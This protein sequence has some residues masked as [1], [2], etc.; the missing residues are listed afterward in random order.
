MTED[1]QSQKY[2]I[3]CGATLPDQGSFCPECGKEIGDTTGSSNS[4]TGD[5]HDLAEHDHNS[6]KEKDDELFRRAE[7]LSDNADGGIIP[8]MLIQTK[9]PHIVLE[10][11]RS[12]GSWMLY[13]RPLIS[14]LDEGEQPHHLLFNRLYGIKIIDP[15]EEPKAPHHKEGRF[16]FLMPTDKRLLYIAAHDE[17]D[18]VREFDYS[19]IDRA[20]WKANLVKDQKLEFVT[21]D[22]CKYRYTHGSMSP[23]NAFSENAAV[24]YIDDKATGSVGTISRLKNEIK[25]ESK[26]SFF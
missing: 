15:D 4:K 2:C 20:E 19:N 6:S 22:G 9:K 26:D 23:T 14:F 12:E 25:R 11:M 24:E 10:N 8:E 3:E 5:S 16:T 18:K 21:T 1:N 13:D 17:E 7:R